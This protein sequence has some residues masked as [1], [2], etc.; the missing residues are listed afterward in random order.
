MKE[1]QKEIVERVW[2]KMGKI[3]GAGGDF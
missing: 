1:K 2:K 3:H